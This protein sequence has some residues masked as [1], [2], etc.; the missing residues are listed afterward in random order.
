MLD[1]TNWQTRDYSTRDGREV[2]ILCADAPGDYPVIGYFLSQGK[3][4]IHSWALNGHLTGVV[5]EQTHDL[6]NVPRKQYRLVSEWMD[7][8]PAFKLLKVEFHENVCGPF[9]VEEREV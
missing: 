8:S 3:P 7:K 1:L 5:Q 2:R 6:I 4:I 9:E